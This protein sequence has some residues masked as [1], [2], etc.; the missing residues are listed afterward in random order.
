MATNNDLDVLDK[1]G[2]NK[3]WNKTKAHVNEKISNVNAK[4]LNGLTTG[5]DNGKIPILV[6]FPSNQQLINLGY[7][8]SENIINA[9]YY[10]KG[11]SKWVYD[12]YHSNTSMNN[13]FIGSVNVGS[14]GFVLMNVVISAGVTSEGYPNYSSGVF[15]GYNTTTNYFGFSNGN[16]NYANLIYR[17]V[18]NILNAVSSKV[19]AN[20]VNSIIDGK[21]FAT[22]TQVDN[23][24]QQI[25]GSAPEDLDTLEEI[26]NKLS[27]GD[28][29]HT[30]LV[31]SISEKAPKSE[32]DALKQLTTNYCFNGIKTISELDNCTENG[33]YI[34]R[35]NGS[36]GVS[37]EYFN[38]LLVLKTEESTQYSIRQTL[39]RIDRL[40][41]T[42]DGLLFEAK[43]RFYDT[44]TNSWVS[45]KTA[46]TDGTNIVDNTITNDKIID[47]T[48]SNS[49]LM[50]ATST[51]GSN[52]IP[53][54]DNN[55]MLPVESIKIVPK[56]KGVNTPGW[57]RVAEIAVGMQQN[58]ILSISKQYSNYHPEAYT[59]VINTSYNIAHI[60]QLSASL[61]NDNINVIDNIRVLINPTG[62]SYI[63]IHY[64]LSS[65]NTLY[66]SC[67]GL[68]ETSLVNF[69]LV[70]DAIPNGYNSFELETCY[71]FKALHLGNKEFK[72]L[73]PLN[74]SINLN[75]VTT[76]GTYMYSTQYSDDT[77][78]SN[79]LQVF[80]ASNY[81]RQTLYEYTGAIKVR[82]YDIIN[83]SWSNW[84][85]T[86][87]PSKNSVPV[88]TVSQF[89]SLGTNHGYPTGTII[90][91]IDNLIS[92]IDNSKYINYYYWNDVNW[93]P[94]NMFSESKFK[95]LNNIEIL[96]LSNKNI[97]TS[98]TTSS[99]IYKENLYTFIIKYKGE[100]FVCSRKYDDA[101]TIIYGNKYK[102]LV[103][104]VNITTTSCNVKF[105]ISNNYT[106]SPYILI[107]YDTSSAGNDI[108]MG[109]DITTMIKHSN[110]G[111]GEDVYEYF[112]NFFG[113]PSNI[114]ELLNLK[115]NV[116]VDGNLN[117][118]LI[119]YSV[120]STA[121]MISITCLNSKD[122]N[123]ITFN[124]DDTQLWYIN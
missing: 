93:I 80:T 96:D 50:S 12:E 15:F 123:I 90:G 58:I 38:L 101:A 72:Q 121:N 113:N 115:I 122:N 110:I 3:L 104:N 29:I 84:I 20:Q 5:H 117:Y 57:Y 4:T 114:N 118:I 23:R 53:I 112:S 37:T 40:N 9:E 48:I 54:T 65:G 22:V 100:T 64:N 1:D 28:D 33:Y 59:F 68:N 35:D 6:N 21:N 89:D 97:N 24:I 34:I 74:T 52:K 91:V 106:D 61:V 108:D 17:D 11:L 116:I 87:D 55:G 75:T 41:S 67:I 27:D 45:W 32:V 94:I 120:S 82:K 73:I 95:N 66:L 69:Q 88:L 49:K 119:P 77:Y 19:D 18:L 111:T 43:I 71:G 86:F 105:T 39:Y 25:I 2:V 70:D 79:V 124:V 102:I 103:T 81:I 13:V 31:Q 76:N 51:P 42:L 7:L 30:A 85:T 36:N 8:S 10:L 62:K 56:Q 107:D 16:W 60:T 83:N 26:A 14:L 98:F 78:Y 99:N 63:D 46:K 109:N 92:V 44:T 47:G